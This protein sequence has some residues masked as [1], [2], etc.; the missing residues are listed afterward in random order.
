VREVFVLQPETLVV[1]VAEAAEQLGEGEFHALRLTVVPGG[2]AEEVAAPLGVD[3]L[4]LL[5]PDDHRE[6]VAPGLDLGRGGEDRDRARGAGRLVAGGRQS[7]Q[8]RIDVEEE[9]AEVAL[10]RVQLGGEVADVADLDVL[11]LEPG[12]LEATQ[13]TLADHRDDVLALLRPVAR[14]VG[15][16][17]AQNVDWRCH[18]VSLRAGGLPTRAPQ[19]SADCAVAQDN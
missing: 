12:G 18:R 14:E 4:H 3:G 16:I 8:R 7:R 2:R 6:V 10:H 9:R 13:H 19:P 1:L 15:L 11:R 17:S 5:D